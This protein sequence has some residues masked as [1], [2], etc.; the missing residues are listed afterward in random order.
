MAEFNKIG[1]ELMGIA[2]D[3]LDHSI[4]DNEYKT[5]VEG[6]ARMRILY[7]RVVNASTP[8]VPRYIP[9]PPPPLAFSNQPLLPIIMDTAVP[10]MRSPS[11]PSRP[12]G[13]V[14]MSQQWRDITQEEVSQPTPLYHRQPRVHGTD[15][16]LEEIG[17]RETCPI[18]TQEVNGR[19][20]GEFIVKEDGFRSRKYK[21]VFGASHGGQDRLLRYPNKKLIASCR[22]RNDLRTEKRIHLVD[23]DYTCVTTRDRSETEINWGWHIN[24]Q[25]GRD[26]MTQA[27]EYIRIARLVLRENDTQRRTIDFQEQLYTL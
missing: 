27:T 10:P 16:R 6:L 12:R 11:P 4:T 15:Y 23:A 18:Y 1:D 5:L 3:V 20:V 24:E 8:S 13:R 25:S 7:E 2:D 19:R 17:Y 14:S 21:V 22:I 26:W 9:P